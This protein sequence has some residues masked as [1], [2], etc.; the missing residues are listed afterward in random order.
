MQTFAAVYAN[1]WNADKVIAFNSSYE[2]GSQN[3]ALALR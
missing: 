3:P 1:V 2:D